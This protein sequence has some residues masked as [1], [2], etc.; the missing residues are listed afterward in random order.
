MLLAYNLSNYSGF[1]KDPRL[2]KIEIH[3]FV[4]KDI[5]L[6]KYA[7]KGNILLLPIAGSGDLTFIYGKF[8][9]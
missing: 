3:V 5:I 8:L 2:N 6:G 7:I 9:I 4:P 1:N